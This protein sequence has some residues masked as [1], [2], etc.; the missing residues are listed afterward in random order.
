MNKKMNK[1]MKT[2]RYK[3]IVIFFCLI[4]F[5]GCSI[6]DTTKNVSDEEILRDR[7]MTYWGYRIEERFDK[8]YEF[9]YPL[10]RKTVSVVDYIRSF[11]PTMKWTNAE[12]QTITKQDDAAEVTVKVDTKVKMSVSKVPKPVEFENKGLVL[13]ERWIKIDDVWYHVPKR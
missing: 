2:L 6:K 4:I 7:I 8:A 11:H 13:N 10:L 3:N 12:I 5:A 9:E 1:K